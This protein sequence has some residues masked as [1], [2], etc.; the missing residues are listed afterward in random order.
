MIWQRVRFVSLAGVVVC[1]AA[2]TARADDAPKMQMGGEKIAA[3]KEAAPATG[4]CDPCAPATKTIKV[5]EYVPT[6]VEETRTVYKQVSTVEKYKAYKTECVEEKKT[7]TVCTTKLVSSVEDRTVTEYTCVPTVE[8]RI[9]TKKVVTCVPVT[10]MV[11]K[12]EDHGH[13]E[14]REEICGPSLFTKAKK[15]FHH[16]ECEC[17]CEPEPVRVKTKK[18]WVPEKVCVQK[19]VTKIE[20]K[21][22]C[23]QE[24]CQV[25]VN[26]MVPT[27]K[28]IKV[29]VCKPVTE[30]KEETYTVLVPKKVEYEATRTVCKLEPVTEKVT[31]CKLVPHTVEKVVSADDSIYH[32]TAK[33]RLFHH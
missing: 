23:V 29:T 16:N 17:A 8:D 2:L 22:E 3:P 1:A 28:T 14:C 4:S 6:Q 33:H 26:K 31:V 7:R 27:T 9:V 18:V 21:V 32:T 13:Y 15:H 25:T 19:P 5:T 30:T 12:I 24:K 11:S 10:V 20:K